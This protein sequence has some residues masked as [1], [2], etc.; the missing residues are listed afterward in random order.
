MDDDRRSIRAAA[1]GE[2]LRSFLDHGPIVAFIKDDDGRYV[3]VNPAMERLFGVAAADIEG[4]QAGAWMPAHLASLI[5]DQDPQVLANGLPL[6]MIAGVPQADG[7]AQYWKIVRFPFVE[8]SGARFVG[9]VAVNVTDLQQAQAK[10]AESERRYRHIVES[11]QGLIC[12]HDMEGRLL[13]VN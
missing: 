4:R 10:L 9:G 7:S 11:G 8:A 2:T 5:R 1:G 3:Y 13:S 6:E 12:T